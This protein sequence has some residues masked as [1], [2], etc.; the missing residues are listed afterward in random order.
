MELFTTY[1]Y[2]EVLE[3]SFHG[4]V[5]E[6]SMFL[7]PLFEDESLC[8]QIHKYHGGDR[9]LSDNVEVNEIHDVFSEN[10]GDENTRHHEK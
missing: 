8:N 1:K 3:E 2:E 7:N 10:D 9:R 4:D 5:S 6:F